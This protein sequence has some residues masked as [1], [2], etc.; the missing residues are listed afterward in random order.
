MEG[1]EVKGS[2]QSKGQGQGESD[3]YLSIAP[4]GPVTKRQYSFHSRAPAVF[5]DE[6][7]DGCAE[8]RDHSCGVLS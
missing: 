6:C 3:L 8:E 4:R 1:K 7:G 5:I 2:M